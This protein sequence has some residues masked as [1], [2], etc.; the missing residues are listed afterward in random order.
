MSDAFW[1]RVS[2]VLGLI[3]LAEIFGLMVFVANIEIK[4]L[5]L[6]LHIGMG[7]YIVQHGFHVPQTDILSCTIAGK[8]WINHEWLF[9]VIVYEVFQKGGAE[10]LLNMQVIVVT[11][12]TV[13]LMLLGY[14]HK[15]QLASIFILLLTSL[16]FQSRFTNRP[17]L[18]SLLFFAIYMYLLAWHIGQ[19][20]SVYALFII[21][22]LWTNIHGFFF[23]G[24]LFIMIALLSE[25]LK[26][27]ARL[28]YEWS[29]IGRL[30]DEEYRRLKIIL[31]LV[32]LACFFNPCTVKGALYPLGVFAQLSGKSKIF[33]QNII[34]LQRPVTWDNLLSATEYPYYKLMILLSFLSFV[35]NR[36]KIDISGLIL[37]LVFLVFSLS[38]LRNVVFFAFAAYLVFVTNAMTISLRDMAPMRI[39][40]KKFIHIMSI[41]VKLFLAMWIL[42]YG[43]S[44]SMNGYYDQDTYEWKSEFGGISQKSYPYKAVDFLVEN[45]VKGNFMNGF[46]TGAYLIGRC[47]PDIKVF[48][49]GR[50]EVYGPDFFKYYRD[51]WEFPEK[52]EVYQALNKY[53]ITG[54]FLHSLSNPIPG[55]LARVINANKEFVL[56][57]LDF[58]GLI[59]LKDI[60]ENK[61]LIDK[62]RI[63]FEHWQP[64]PMDLLSLGS[65][66]VIPT[67]NINRAYTLDALGY[68]DAAL[69]ELE[70]ALQ[71]TPVN[72]EPYKLRGKIYAERKDFRKAFE[73]FRIAAMLNTG[74]QKIRMNLALSCYDMGEYAHAAEQYKKIINKWPD[75]PE[76][77][78]KLARVYVKLNQFDRAVNVLREGIQIDPRASTDALVIS[79]MLVEAQAYEPAREV[80]ERII[81]KDKDGQIHYKLGQLYQL[82]GKQGLA[83][84]E[85][86][87]ARKM[88]SDN[89]EI[90]NT[91]KEG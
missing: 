27:H 57:Y 49:D 60:P 43:E 51:M 35:F 70:V 63:D 71:V 72:Y 76:G 18:F 66:K 62:Y 89:K 12:A 36:R 21:Q 53:K 22:I 80:L 4:D 58:D 61:A 82:T 1:R 59:Y 11:L 48:M 44:M 74:D 39:I 79:D 16:V 19:R 37:W 55:K 15:K 29:K 50:T 54:V 68:G 83:S 10:G 25:W 3:V 90:E 46:N 88:N 23:F 91:P 78:F 69:S 77:Y 41:V 33:F 32:V 7:K 52:E 9:Q 2:L 17:D 42:Q 73:N 20:W 85:F 75:A 47:F 5:D 84:E 24:P 67:R 64:F 87:K 86:E 30:T 34:E 26:R 13:L 81:D 56:V 65:K 14:N 45:K 6:W 28:P 8:P 31:G 40:D 38:A